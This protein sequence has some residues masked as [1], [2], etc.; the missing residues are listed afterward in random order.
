MAG[1]YRAANSVMSR[2]SRSILF[3]PIA[4]INDERLMIMLAMRDAGLGVKG[5]CEPQYHKQT[6]R[7]HWL[8]QGSLS[9]LAHAEAAGVVGAQS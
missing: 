2:P 3:I 1:E 4:T 6:C 7:L 8:L 9:A 5:L